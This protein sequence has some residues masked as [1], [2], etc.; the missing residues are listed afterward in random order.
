MVSNG[1]KSRKESSHDSHLLPVSGS[2]T[3]GCPCNPTCNQSIHLFQLPINQQPTSL[4]IC[5]QDNRNENVVRLLITQSFFLRYLRIPHR[6]NENI[7]ANSPNNGPQTITHKLST[8]II[9]QLVNLCF[10][11]MR[12]PHWNPYLPTVL[13]CK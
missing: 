6:V 3:N 2:S 10:K 9:K 1:T 4:A 12:L 5:K 11:N 8:I 7:P 13:A